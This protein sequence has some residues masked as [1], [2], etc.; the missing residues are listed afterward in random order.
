[1]AWLIGSFILFI[2]LLLIV[3]ILVFKKSKPSEIPSAPVKK[4]KITLESLTQ[5]LKNEKKEITK[6]E[7]ALDKMASSFPFPDNE[8]DANDHFKF[9]YFYAKNPLT[10]AKMIVKMQKKLSQINPKYAKQIENFQMIGVE[11][12]KK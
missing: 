11:A 9:V 8:K 5:V 12:R 6:I 7:D 4:T 3:V 10:D 1:M 2:L